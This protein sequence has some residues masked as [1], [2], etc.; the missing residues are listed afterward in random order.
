[1]TQESLGLLVGYSPHGTSAQTSISKIEEGK[2]DPSEEQLI[3]LGRALDVSLDYLAGDADTMERL[4][5]NFLP[6]DVEAVAAGESAEGV[7]VRDRDTPHCFSRERLERNGIA[8]ERA[9]VFQVAGISMA[10]TLADGSRV[11]TDRGSKE[12]WPGGIYV[13]KRDGHLLVK[14]FATDDAEPR[15]E[16][17]NKDFDPIHHDGSISVLGEVRWSLQRFPA[18]R[19]G[20]PETADQRWS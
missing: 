9:T 13:I 11:I 5:V 1:M 20:E 6:I 15:W 14:R 2:S 8:P 12:P 10:P 18:S 19:P 7:E 4:S 3:E 16:S 17:E